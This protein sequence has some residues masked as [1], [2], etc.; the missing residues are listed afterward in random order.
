V[1]RSGCNRLQTKDITSFRVKF[2]LR[3]NPIKPF[4]VSPVQRENIVLTPKRLI[5]TETSFSNL[6]KSRTPAQR[7]GNCV[8]AQT[9]AALELNRVASIKFV[10]SKSTVIDHEEPPLT[11]IR[12]CRA[13]QVFDS[14][15][16][17]RVQCLAESPQPDRQSILQYRSYQGFFSRRQFST[18]D[19]EIL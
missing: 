17:R 19:R 12:E 8:A 11:S 6:L 7:G 3:V 15:G 18:V 5:S 13:G 4:G 14:A 10:G 2:P 9:P 16:T 1:A